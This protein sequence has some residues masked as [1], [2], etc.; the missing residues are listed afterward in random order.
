MSAKLGGDAARMAYVDRQE[1]YGD[2]SANLSTCGTVWSEILGIEP[3]PPDMVALMMC[4]MKLIRAANR[5]NRDDLVDAVA[6][7]MLADDIRED[8]E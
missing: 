2:P 6:Y 3:I 1:D 7:L 5:I 4:S 8:A